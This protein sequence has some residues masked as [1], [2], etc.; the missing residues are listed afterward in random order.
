MGKQLSMRNL[1]YII[2]RN[3]PKQSKDYSK[4]VNGNHLKRVRG[5]LDDDKSN[6]KLEVGGEY[7]ETER[8]FAPTILSS[9]SANAKVMQDEVSNFIFSILAKLDDDNRFLVPFCQFWIPTFSLQI[10]SLAPSLIT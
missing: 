3:N 7:D 8:Y 5:L 1:V 4:V 10:I 2:C 6:Y 9:V